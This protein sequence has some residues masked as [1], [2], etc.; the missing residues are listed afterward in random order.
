MRFAGMNKGVL[1]AIGAYVCW[2]LV[3]IFW[4]QLHEVDSLQ[5]IAH[6]IVWSVVTLVVVMGFVSSWSDFRKAAASRNVLLL[7]AAASVLVAINWL[8]YV[9]AVNSGHIVETS[10]GYFINPILSVL[11]GVIFFKERLRIWQWIPIGLAACGVLYLSFALGSVPWIAVSLACSFSIYGA[12]KKIA[13][14][15][16]LFGLTLE[17]SLLLIPALIFLCL[18]ESKGSGVFLHSDAKISG[19]LVLGGA[20]TTFPLLLF[21]SAAQKIPLSTIGMLQYLAPT[22]QFLCGVVIYKEGFSSDQFIGYGM[23]WLALIILGMN[24]YHAHRTRL[25][26]PE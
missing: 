19:L 21:G 26:V 22:L 17:T 25:V 3:P 15:N 13:P 5:V 7:Y 20:I 16:P 6:R 2:G 4:K 11:L 9:W 1:H 12:I 8:I 18:L 14:L 23:V 24:S 10:L